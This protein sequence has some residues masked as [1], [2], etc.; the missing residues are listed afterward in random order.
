MSLRL[1][2]ERVKCLLHVR[3]KVLRGSGHFVLKH[4]TG[5][6]YGLDVVGVY[7]MVLRSF[8]VFPCSNDVAA[9]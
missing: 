6:R 2:R 4:D 9:L 8:V 1:S 3:R 5:T 7:T